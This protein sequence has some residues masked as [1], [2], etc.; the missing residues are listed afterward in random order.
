MAKRL[1]NLAKKE[2]RKG[3]GISSIYLVYTA[4]F[5]GYPFVWLFILLF[6]RWRFVGTPQFA[7]LY[8]IQRVLTDPLFWKTVGNVFRFMLYYIP[9]VLLGSLLFAIALNKLKVGKTF[10]ALSFLVANV[11]SGVA[12][13][14]MFSNLF[15]VNGP[16]NRTLYNV[17]GITIPWFTSPQLA[18][19]SISLIVIWKFIGYYGLIL[20]AG[21]T[22]IPKSL[23]EAAEL[24]GAGNLTKFFRI[25]L[26]LLNPSIVMVM[27][28]AITLAFGIFTEP[29][30]ITG[31]GPMRSTLTPMMHMITTAFQRMD[32]TYA[33]TMAVFVAIISF[34]L[35]LVVRKT[36]E[37]E[38]D[39]V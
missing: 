29:Y 8:N 18:M 3:L 11:S 37:R 38:V 39:L 19:F 16:I 1:T 9:F 17:F 10:V 22:A 6:S 28:L 5:W 36:I 21:L 15:S 14:I 25:T 30:M 7:G 2:A 26:P 35:I 24:D 27:V 4:I 31:G 12:Y 34:G 32:P 20:Y 33:A 23:Y 13:S